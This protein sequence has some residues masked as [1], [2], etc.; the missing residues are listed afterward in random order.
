MV[1]NSKL[2]SKITGVEKNN[3]ILNH[4]L[5]NYDALNLFLNEVGIKAKLCFMYFKIRKLRVYKTLN[6]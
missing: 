2:R 5:V 3:F 6:I 4:L 1:V